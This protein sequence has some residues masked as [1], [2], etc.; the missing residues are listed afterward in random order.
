[1]HNPFS[2]KLAAVLILACAGAGPATA[3]AIGMAPIDRLVAEDDIRQQLALYALLADGDGISPKDIDTLATK[4]TAPDVV[5]EIFPADGGPPTHTV[6][7]AAVIGPR[8]TGT[9]PPPTNVSRHYLVDT[10]FDEI[11]P[12]TART[13]TTSVHFNL[14]KNLVGKDCLQ[15]GAG[16]CGGQVNK[17]TMWTYHMRW[18]KNADG[19]Q[20]GYNAL[21]MDH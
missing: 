15:R 20:I 18:V 5:T 6:G 12:T 16:A 13:R 4:I 2:H 1:M 9:P 11:T 19:W 3:A 7:R 8:P 14:T 10:Y 17:V 21:H